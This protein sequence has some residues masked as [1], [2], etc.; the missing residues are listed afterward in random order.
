MP[1]QR[2]TCFNKIYSCVASF[3]Q[4][5]DGGLGGNPDVPWPDRAKSLIY[6]FNSKGEFRTRAI[7]LAFITVCGR[8]PRTLRHDLCRRTEHNPPLIL[9]N[10][11]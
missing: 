4:R 9:S 1:A 2:N 3:G 7:D 11:P 8:T 6:R 10:H 5:S